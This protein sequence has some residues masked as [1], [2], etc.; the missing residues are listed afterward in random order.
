MSHAEESAPDL[1]AGAVGQSE[2]SGNAQRPQGIHRKMDSPVSA[3]GKGPVPYDKRKF[4]YDLYRAQATQVAF[5]VSRDDRMSAEEAGATLHA[6][7]EMVGI[8][9]AEEHFIKAFDDALFFYHTLNSASVLQPGRGKIWI[10]GSEFDMSEIVK[11]VGVDIRRFFRAFADEIKNVNL[12]V[13]KDYDPYD[14]VKNE[15]HG[16]IMQV[17][18][19]R[20]IH[21]FPH[22]AHDS[23]DACTDI[24]IAERIAISNS[25]KLVISSTINAVDRADANSRVNSGRGYDSTNNSVQEN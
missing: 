21:R 13:L 10:D 23:A 11:K 20:G 4:K 19:E 8:S 9:R 16:W 3:I 2:S 7:H 6:I 24:S 14:P 1:Y 12:A 22:L 17:A 18:L 25:K 15:K 5:A